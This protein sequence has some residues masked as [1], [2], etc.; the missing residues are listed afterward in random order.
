MR[1]G[2][3]AVMIEDQLPDS[4]NEPKTEVDDDYAPEEQ[5]QMDQLGQPRPN[6]RSRDQVNFT[7]GFKKCRIGPNMDPE[8]KKKAPKL[9]ETC[10]RNG[11]KTKEKRLPNKE[12]G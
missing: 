3:G 11:P 2:I 6:R 4:E 1:S 8:F 5:Q 7:H 12:Q 9:S 10:S